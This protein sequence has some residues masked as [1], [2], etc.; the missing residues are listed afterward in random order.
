MAQLEPYD[1]S[2]IEMIDDL[3]VIC[4][5]MSETTDEMRS[6]DPQYSF[7]HEGHDQLGQCQVH[8]S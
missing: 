4:P 3:Y 1:E 2:C 5:W 6:S 8:C 7:G